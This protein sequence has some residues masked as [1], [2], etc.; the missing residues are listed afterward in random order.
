MSLKTSRYARATPAFITEALGLLL[1]YNSYKYYL[2]TIYNTVLLVNGC[3]ARRALLIRP[4][5]LF[6]SIHVHYKCHINEVKSSRTCL[7]NH[8]ESKSRYITPL[9][10]NSLGGGHT[11]TQT[12]THTHTYQRRGQKQFQETRHVPACGRRAPGLK[13]FKII[14]R[15]SNLIFFN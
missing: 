10:I 12:H 8:T 5:P 15:K 9:V 1:V 3:L 13:T 4:R 2:I 14:L 7:T 6:P 11:D